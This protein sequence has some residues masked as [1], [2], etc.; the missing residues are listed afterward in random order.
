[1]EDSHLKVEK[2]ET[3]L[4][5]VNVHAM[6]EKDDTLLRDV[7]TSKIET[8][9]GHIEEIASSEPRYRSG[10]RRARGRRARGR[11]IGPNLV[12]AVIE[13]LDG[14]ATIGE[15]VTSMRRALGRAATCST[16]PCRR[17]I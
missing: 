16:I 6:A 5:G 9:R 7:A 10:L 8:W 12:V 11:P 2:G 17:R 15:I 4:V 14:S 3:P 1:M 13:A